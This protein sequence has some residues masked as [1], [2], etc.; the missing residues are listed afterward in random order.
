MNKIIVNADDFGASPEINTAID[1]AFKKGIINRATLMVNMPYA[2]DAVQQAIQEGYIDRIGLH[3]CFDTGEPLTDAIKEYHLFDTKI[4]WQKKKNRIFI[5]RVARKALEQ[6]IEAQMQKYVSMG[7]TAM[8]IDSHHHL[9]HFPSVL[10]SVIKLAKKYGFKS[11]RI[12]R[13]IGYGISPFS[14]IVKFFLNSIIACNFKTSKYFGNMQNYMDSSLH[15]KESLEI[16]VHPRIENGKYID[17]V[18]FERQYSLDEYSA[19]AI[20]KKD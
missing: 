4:F 16:M 10:P 12:S 20:L 19:L 7:C 11:M 6:E 13:N 1:Y 2:Q 15:E 17:W 18:D 9:H 14:R 8:H 5:P 3:L